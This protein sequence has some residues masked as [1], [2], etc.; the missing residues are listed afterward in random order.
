MVL[1]NKIR[2]SIFIRSKVLS[3]LLALAFLMGFFGIPNLKAQT[4]LTS[5]EIDEYRAHAEQLVS[6]LQF[7]FNTIGDPEVSVKDKDIII[8]QSYSKIFESDK[9][10]IEDDLVV[11]REIPINKDVQAYLKD[12]DFFY[13]E[14]VFEFRIE[15]ITQEINEKNQL[16]FKIRLNR[17]LKGVTI[18][19]DTLNTNRTR[20]IEIN[21]NDAQKDL[22][23]ASI[24]TTKLNEKEELRKWWNDLPLHWKEI[25]G[26][27]IVLADTINMKDVLYFN[28]SIAYLDFLTS[29]RMSRDTLS[30]FITDTLKIILNDTAWL[31]TALLDRQLI[32]IIGL[33]TINISSN[34]YINSLEPVSKLI[35]LK[36]LDCSNTSISDL[37]PLRNLTHLQF[38]DC[39]NTSVESIEPLRYSNE[40]EHLFFSNT[41]VSNIATLS[42]FNLLETLHFNQTEI[43]SLNPISNLFQLTDFEFASTLINDISPLGELSKLERL[44]FSNTGV[45]D[46]EPLKKL[47]EIY[48]LKFD[49]TV[50]KNLQPLKDL[51]SLQLLFIDN[52]PV[53][54]ISSLSG[55]PELNRIYCDQTGITRNLANKFMEENPGVLVIYESAALINWWN[56]LPEEWRTYFSQFI[57][58]GSKP[59]KEDLH[60][61]TKIKSVD[62]SGLSVITTIEPL[63]NLAMLNSLKCPGTGIQNLE[64]LRELADLNTLD[65]SNTEVADISVLSKLSKLQELRFDDTKVSD[66]DPIMN[67]DELKLVYCDNSPVDEAWIMEFINGHQ[68][69]QVIYQTEVLEQWW[70]NIPEVW[71]M[72]AGKFINT[73]ENLTREQLHQIARLQRIDIADFPEMSKQSMQI[74]SLEY[75]NKLAFLEEFSFTNTRVT[76][77]EPLRGMNSIKVL[78]CPN[79][80]IESLEPLS[81]VKNLE[82]LDAKNTPIDKLDFLSTLDGLKKLNCSGTNIKS[83]KG[84]E[85]LINLEEIECHNTS[86]KNLKYLE[87]LENLNSV[88]CYNTRINQRTIDK[89]KADRPDVEVVFY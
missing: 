32:K 12:I 82:V 83:L 16:F 73:K 84:L 23:I 72:L 48:F 18:E 13:Q 78:N 67:L 20:Y 11:E 87:N 55:L 44:D 53:F 39:S 36:R 86:I 8:N 74:T 42:N 79:N 60:E 28:D 24:Y 58:S 65:F 19:G 69:C 26:S 89:F 27:T 49:N 4:A 7:T 35:K 46:I 85:Y 77:L 2:F 56:E 22:K 14:V 54:D 5:D 38:L 1:Q 61:I 88:K 63:Q 64:P 71:K 57:S 33:D 15:E 40:L 17:N 75:I 76:S 81:E 70:A 52:T 37:M 68:E 80:P 62:V 59:K 41:E 29:Q 3:G 21:L 50:V 10:Q 47:K 25:F 31:N 30:L 51:A 66:I 34:P 9:V 45:N 6:F 43:D